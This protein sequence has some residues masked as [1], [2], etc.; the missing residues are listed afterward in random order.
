MKLEWEHKEFIKPPEV[1]VTAREGWRCLCDGGIYL[2]FLCHSFLV[3]F[4]LPLSFSLLLSLA[5]SFHV[6]L[7]SSPLSLSDHLSITLFLPHLTLFLF[8][9]L[10]PPLCPCCSLFVFLLSHCLSISHSAIPSTQVSRSDDNL[11]TESLP[12]QHETRFLIFTSS[13]SCSPSFSTHK[14][15]WAQRR[16]N[17]PH[18]PSLLRLP[19]LC[20]SQLLTQLFLR[21]AAEKK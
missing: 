14:L 18:L 20:I 5:L 21:I 11:E 2:S 7:S 9:S 10:S 6:S 15:G 12:A 1:T 17:H 16:K 8:L 13:T 4:L 19:T 3:C